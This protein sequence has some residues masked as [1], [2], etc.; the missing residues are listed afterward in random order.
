MK[1][2]RSDYD[3]IQDP[4]HLIPDDEPVFLLR[5]QDLCAPDTLSHWAHLAEMRGAK[6]DIINLVLDQAVAMR[7]WQRE[8]GV[9]KVPDLPDELAVTPVY[10]FSKIPIYLLTTIPDEFFSP[11]IYYY[12]RYQPTSEYQETQQE[13]ELVLLKHLTRILAFNTN[14][15]QIPAGLPRGVINDP[16]LHAVLRQISQ[17]EMD[18]AITYGVNPIL[19]RPI[20]G[21]L[22]PV[23][24]GNKFISLS[25]RELNIMEHPNP[26]VPVTAGL[27]TVNPE[28]HKLALSVGAVA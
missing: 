28:F 1:H 8:H 3:R 10:D 21:Q 27:C 26:A 9:G 5:G 24:W 19:L 11:G 4:A 25:S 18:Q 13:V 17:S 7:K 23:V 2:A 22:L 12:Y 15:G 6:P 16:T 20:N 14:S